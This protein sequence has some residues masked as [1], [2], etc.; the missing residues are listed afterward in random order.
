MVLFVYII[1]FHVWGGGEIR[2]FYS[3]I[4]IAGVCRSI[5]ITG[6]RRKPC[7]SID[8]QTCD[9]YINILC[10]CLNAKINEITPNHAWSPNWN[11]NSPW[12][13]KS[14]LLQPS[15]GCVQKVCFFADQYPMCSFE[16]CWE[17]DLISTSKIDWFF[18]Y[19][20]NSQ[21]TSVP[22]IRKHQG[23]KAP[24][25]FSYQNF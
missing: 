10:M 23:P 5:P 21:S 22:T 12:S 6:I 16:W 17:L 1:V 11:A 13:D 14:E 18:D 7:D 4:N 19:L 24:G 25:T 9:S 15:A 8:K 2:V 20:G 3:D